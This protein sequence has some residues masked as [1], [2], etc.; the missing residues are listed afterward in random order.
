MAIVFYGM[1][2]ALQKENSVKDVYD[3]LLTVS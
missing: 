3:A 2:G 1:K